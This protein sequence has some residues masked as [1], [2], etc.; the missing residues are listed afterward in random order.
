MS[1]L[2]SSSTVINIKPD[3][4][5]ANINVTAR[6]DYNLRFTKQ[7]VLVVGDSNDDYSQVARQYLVAISNQE[8]NQVNTA[9]VSASSK[10]NDIQLRCR[11]IEQLFSNTL[12]DPEQSLVQSV[13]RLAQ[14]QSDV[15]TIIIEHAQALSLQIKYELCQLVQVAKKSNTLINVIFFGSFDSGKEVVGDK[16]L[17]KNKLVIID[18]LTGQLYNYDDPKLAPVVKPIKVHLWQKIVL[19]LSVVLLM[20]ACLALFIYI[21][22]VDNKSLF[23]QTTVMADKAS[24]DSFSKPI[25]TFIA[26]IT[27]SNDKQLNKP[28]TTVNEANATDIYQALLNDT[29]LKA[30]QVANSSEVFNALFAT[31]ST[32]ALEEA[33]E[34]TEILSQN[35]EAIKASETLKNNTSEAGSYYAQ[36][37][38]LAPEGY[39]IQIAGF[40]DNKRL[41]EFLTTYETM[42]LHHYTKDLNGKVFTVVTSD[43]YATKEDAKAAIQAFPDDL[44]VR[45]PWIKPI[46]LVLAEI[47]TFK[48]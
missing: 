22:D 48:E 24:E 11:L 9:F 12:F 38:L 47:N 44:V 39:V 33:S 3:N 25:A 6:I 45:D 43:N 1:A 17:F 35:N 7:A 15:L 19:G 34:D 21:S 41:T 30:P 27:D 36:A 10:L 40:F 4:S 31:T 29:E 16:T 42:P 20:A 5:I 14:Q 13:L 18:A 2:P 8:T 23:T 32:A 37:A 46:S 26:P 28:A